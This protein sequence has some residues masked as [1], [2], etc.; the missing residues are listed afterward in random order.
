MDF[1]VLGWVVESSFGDWAG[2]IVGRGFDFGF[3]RDFG[4][5]LACG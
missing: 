1:F 2:S 4:G 3:G 5:D